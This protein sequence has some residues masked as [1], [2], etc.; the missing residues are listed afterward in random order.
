M[1]RLKK[2]RIIAV[3]IGG[4]LLLWFLYL[5]R[6]ALVPFLYGLLLAYLLDPMVN[7]LENR[8][9]SRKIAI[10]LVYVV[11]GLVIFVISYYALPIL[12]RDLNKILVDIPQ[13]TN[14]V[15]QLI[16]DFQIGYQRVPIPEGIRT[17]CDQMIAEAGTKAINL[18]QSIMRGIVSL[19]S[20]TINFVL[21]PILAF[22]LLL[23]FSKLGQFCLELVP[24]R[25]RSELAE[26]GQE[27]G[28][29]IKRF[30]RGNLLVS[31]LIGVVAV[32]GLFLIGMDYP[33]L[34]GIMVG[35]TNFIPYFGAVIS[36]VL[37][38]FVALL[39]SKWLALYVLGLMLVIQQLEGNIIAPKILGDSVGLHPLAI[40][41]VLLMA[42]ELFGLVGLLVAVPVAAILKVLARH[43]F[44]HLIK[45]QQT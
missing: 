13:Y 12:A 21:A 39:K 30:I 37:A 29:I 16:Q 41:L 5:V 31:L 26:L 3:I 15:Q 2:I 33:L 25:Y 4:A 40:I 9:V 27:I 35:I 32:V 19:F 43:A 38:V 17:V 34:L 23:E 42:G 7:W 8:K 44:N 18:T 36:A 24:T 1:G 45:Y 28:L 20:Q 22:Y 11:F 6:S 10:I 14:S